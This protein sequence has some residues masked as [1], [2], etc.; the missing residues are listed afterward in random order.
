MAHTDLG[1]HRNWLAVDG[2]SLALRLLDHAGIAQA[3]VIK[4]LP[5]ELRL[6]LHEREP[7]LRVVLADGSWGLLDVEGVVLAHAQKVAGGMQ[8]QTVYG[9]GEIAAGK[10]FPTVMLD[11]PQ[12]ELGK[13]LE[14]AAL[15]R[16]IKVLQAAAAANWPAE[17]P[18]LVDASKPYE[19]RVEAPDGAKLRF[20]KEHAV[21]AFK[22]W[23]KNRSIQPHLLAKD[24]IMDMVGQESRQGTLFI[25]RPLAVP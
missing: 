9:S 17:L 22:V 19:V 20:E 5:G 8:M 18:L 24:M 11:E 2:Y 4:L 10:Y 25:L 6:R 16:S 3:D 12:L 7:I 13:P 1:R 15:E 14:S 23:M 21:S